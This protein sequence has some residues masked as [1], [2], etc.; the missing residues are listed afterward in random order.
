MSPSHITQM[1]E[2]ELNK[3]NSNESCSQ[4]DLKFLFNLKEGIHQN[5]ALIGDIATMFY[6]SKVNPELWACWRKKNLKNLQMCQKWVFPSRN[7][8]GVEIFTK[9][10]ETSQSFRGHERI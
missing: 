5:I 7:R 9:S 8:E 6:Q 1:M 3:R 10:V 2:L 4:D